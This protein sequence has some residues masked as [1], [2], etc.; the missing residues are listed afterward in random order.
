[1][2]NLWSVIM[3]HINIYKKF[4]S[5]IKG[6]YKFFYYEFLEGFANANIIGFGGILSEFPL[7]SSILVIIFF[8]SFFYNL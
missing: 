2:F 5:S 1:M 4:F 8:I 6:W 7:L 3:T